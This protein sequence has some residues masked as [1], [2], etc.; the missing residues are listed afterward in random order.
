MT[1][2]DYEF[3]IL[4]LPSVCLIAYAAWIRHENNKIERGKGI[5]ETARRT[6]RR[7]QS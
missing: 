7:T 5:D 3:L 4:I 2:S 1:A 6:T